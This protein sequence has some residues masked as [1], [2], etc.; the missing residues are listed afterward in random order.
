MNRMARCSCGKTEPS[1]DKAQLAFFEFR[2]V[3]SKEATETCRHCG[4]HAVAH[5]PEHPRRVA[6]LD[7]EPRGPQ[8]FDLFYCGCRGWE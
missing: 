6:C 2:G 5:Q 8:E 7:F 3:G 1:S 4:Y